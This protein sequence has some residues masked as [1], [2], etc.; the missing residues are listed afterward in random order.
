MNHEKVF[1]DYEQTNINRLFVLNNEDYAEFIVEV[2]KWESHFIDFRVYNNIKWD[3]SD[4]EP[5]EK[6][7]YL[8]CS[9]KWDGCSHFHFGEGD[10][11]GRNGYLHI[12]GL[13][14]YYEHVRLME[15]LYEKAFWLMDK[16]PLDGNWHY[17]DL[18]EDTYT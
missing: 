17:D 15:F 14:S 1:R 10:R 7:D 6:E 16:E 9:I 3:M 11:G 13:E 4:P 5:F 18:I 2:T 12:C 8:E